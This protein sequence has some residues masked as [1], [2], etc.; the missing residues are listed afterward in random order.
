MLEPDRVVAADED[1]E[2][3]ME[4]AAA[5]AAAMEM[6]QRSLAANQNQKS[7]IQNR[8]QKFQRH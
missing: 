3:A 5:V 1:V 4:T 6:V 8:I 2:M 7:K